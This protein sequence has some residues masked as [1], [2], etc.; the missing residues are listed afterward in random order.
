[1]LEHLTK[2][3]FLGELISQHLLSVLI[4][5]PILGSL[6]L[7]LPLFSKRIDKESEGARNVAFLIS[8]LEFL[9]SVAL[10][11]GYSNTPDVQFTEQ[12]MWLKSYG[13]SYFV[14][15]DG[16]SLPLVLLTTLIF[17]LVI[18]AAKNTARAK[19]GYLAMMLWLEGA[20][21]GAMLSLDLFVFY[22]FWELMLIPMYFII[23]IWGAEDRIHATVKFVL[24]TMLG[25]FAMLGAIFYLGYVHNLQAGHYSFALNDLLKVGL[26]NKEELYL[27]IAFALAFA[28]K[29]PIFPLHTWL[30]DAHVQAPTGGSVVLAAVLLKL[31]IYGFLRF[32][33]PLFPRVA[34]DSVYI[35]A[36]LGIIGIIYGAFAALAQK[37]MKK[38]VAYSSVSHLGYCV[39]GLAAVRET[40]ALTGSVFQMVA[41]GLATAALFF[42]VGALYERRHTKEIAEYG[43]IASQMPILAFVFMM[44]LLSSIALPLTAGFVGE[45]TILAAAYN[46]FKFWMLP[47]FLGV[48][49]GAVYM[50]T[51]YKKVMFGKLNTEKNGALK[52]LGLEECAVFVPLIIF[53][54]VLGVMPKAL[55]AR[56]EPSVMGVQQQMAQRASFLTNREAL[57]GQRI[58][59][60]GGLYATVK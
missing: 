7:L 47:A 40:A 5:F 20:V 14:G 39:L 18:M 31:G 8:F 32:A 34:L 42:V 30:P 27:F 19:R 41:H 33:F 12:Y 1:M 38:L 50:L 23:G 25:S 45:F 16:I 10:L 24:Y 35:F 53:I 55:N 60:G 56:I 49:M 13:I 21:I 26:S 3:P 4:V 6:F 15:I 48:V 58:E 2:I 22:L 59:L 54:F 11:Q 44:A 57:K 17:P 36:T 9:L 29:V 43:G 52:D 28:I 37:D 46:S 51:L